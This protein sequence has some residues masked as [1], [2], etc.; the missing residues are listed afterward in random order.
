MEIQLFKPVI[1][2]LKLEIFSY[3]EKKKEKE[4]LV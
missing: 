4:F 3:A 1:S 2:A